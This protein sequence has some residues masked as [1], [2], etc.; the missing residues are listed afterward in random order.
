M[1]WWHLWDSAYSTIRVAMPMYT[2]CTTRD[3]QTKAHQRSSRL[4]II[5]SDLFFVNKYNDKLGLSSAKLSSSWGKLNLR[6]SPSKKKCGCLQLKKNLRSS[7]K[8]EVVFHLPKKLWS[9]SCCFR[10]LMSS[11]IYS[12]YLC[13]IEFSLKIPHMGCL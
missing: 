10:K 2:T 11:S 9:S 13:V 8:T 7:T 4:R 5:L 1:H 3:K 12:K 6:L